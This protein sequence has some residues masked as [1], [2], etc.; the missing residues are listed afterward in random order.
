MSA[1]LRTDV[2]G[3]SEECHGPIL[4]SVAAPSRAGA[5]VE[6]RGQVVGGGADELDAP[7]VGLVIRLGALETGQERMVNVDGPAD[8][9][10]AARG[11]MR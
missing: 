11:V 5:F 1:E 2:D 10:V 6:I 9:P 8:D 7:V 3:Q 4:R